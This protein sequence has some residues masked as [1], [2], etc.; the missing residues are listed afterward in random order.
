MP[1]DFICPICGTT[2]TDTHHRLY[3]SN[4]CRAVAGIARLVERNKARRRY[5]AV[6]G[7]TRY[8]VWWRSNESSRYRA[9][10]RDRRKRQELVRILGARCVRCGYDDIRALVLDH[11]NGDGDSDRKKIGS[12]IARYYA[13]HPDEARER[14]QVLC[15]N[16]NLIK[17]QENDEHN[18]T[19]R[20]H[21]H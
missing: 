6:D 2:F 21:K 12:R 8:Q 14:L 10:D 20:V 17:T 5:P 1:R 7:L 3:C 11:K 4:H 15:A 19:R 16:C 18:K 13:Q 9:L